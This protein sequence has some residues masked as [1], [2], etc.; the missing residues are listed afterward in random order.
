MSNRKIATGCT[1]TIRHTSE[2]LEAHVEL[3]D[4]LKPSPGDRVIVHGASVTVP[5]GESASIRR[6]ATLIR[7][8]PLQKLWVRLKSRLE[9]TEL[10]EVSFTPGRLR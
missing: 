6:L 2:T 5:F 1:I 4:G 9:V 8:T 10:Y 3:D 7:A